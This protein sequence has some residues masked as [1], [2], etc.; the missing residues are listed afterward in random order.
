[1]WAATRA[2]VTRLSPK[3]PEAI[4]PW[5]SIICH[6]VLF[7]PGFLSHV[8]LLPAALPLFFLLF[9]LSCAKEVSV[10]VRIRIIPPTGLSP[11]LVMRVLL[12]CCCAGCCLLQTRER[13]MPGFRPHPFSGQASPSRPS[14]HFPHQA[15][16]FK[17]NPIALS[18]RLSPPPFSFSF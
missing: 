1:M 6:V 12:Y 5:Y 7:E 17:L 3:G 2:A 8:L 4:V 15:P 14:Q 13:A 16:P 18:P 9:C 10:R 11:E